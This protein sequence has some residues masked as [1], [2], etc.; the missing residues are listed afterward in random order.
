MNVILD[1]EDARAA[2]KKARVDVDQGI[3][4]SMLIRLL[5]KKYATG[6]MKIGDGK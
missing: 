5:V 1:D 4:L 2:V 3:S 6:N